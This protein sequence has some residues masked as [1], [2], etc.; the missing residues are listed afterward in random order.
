[1]RELSL[2]VNN[3]E[4]LSSIWIGRS[5]ISSV[6]S[7]IDLTQYSKVVV[8]GDSGAEDSVSSTIGSLKEQGLCEGHESCLML[9]GGEACKSLDRLRD[10]WEFF[11]GQRLDR[12]AAVLAV[13]GGAITDLVGFAAATYMRGI[14]FYA[15][16]TTLLSQVDASVGGKSGINFA[17]AKNI[18][19]SISQPRA[20]I[21]DVDTL[22]TL[23]EREHRSGFA[24]IVKHGLIVD[25]AYYDHV[26]SRHHKDWSLDELVEIIYRS[27]QIKAQVVAADETEQG[28]RK[29]LNFGHTL[30][31]AIEAWALGGGMTS[32]EILTHGEA[33]SIGMH[34]AASISFAKGLISYEDVNEIRDAFRRVGLPTN[35]PEPIAFNSIKA[36]LSKDKKTIKGQ[37]RWILLSAI[38]NAICNQ[39]VDEEIVLNVWEMLNK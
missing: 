8:V 17:G 30:G 38:G 29:N 20:V 35:L 28:P 31:H 36:L 4:K 16:P 33:I 15:V 25:R 5:L 24:E 1:M 22:G 2:K 7:L 32:G 14:D 21:I 27:C 39:Q 23:S 19:G 37:T 34:G 9:K 10:V 18:L 11:V 6:G 12:K 26:T 13:G 3:K